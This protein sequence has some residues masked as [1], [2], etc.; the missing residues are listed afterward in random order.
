MHCETQRI[1]KEEYGV[2]TAVAQELV[3]GHLRLLSFLRCWNGRIPSGFVQ[4]LEAGVR[5]HFGYLP[6]GWERMWGVCSGVCA[7]EMLVADRTLKYFSDPW[8]D[9]HRFQP[10]SRSPSPSRDIAPPIPPS[11]SASS[12]PSP[13]TTTSNTTYTAHHDPP[14]GTRAPIIPHAPAKQSHRSPITTSS[15]RPS[16]RRPHSTR[17]FIYID[18]SLP[19]PSLCRPAALDVQFVDFDGVRFRLTTPDRKVPTAL[20]LSMNIRCWDELV[21]YGVNEVLAR[22]YTSLL[23]AEPENGYNVTLD[24]NLEQ[25]PASGGECMCLATRALS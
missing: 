2:R 6:G 11:L 18:R 8:I 1:S 24:V 12:S 3:Q 4:G 17:I 9:S 23:R 25:L 19:N 5:T 7:L 14:R 15:T 22:E 10:F 16:R 21:R 13:T 20:V